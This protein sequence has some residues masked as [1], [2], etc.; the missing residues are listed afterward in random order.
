MFVPYLIGCS[1]GS[2]LRHWVLSRSAP[3]KPAT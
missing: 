2:L 3:A 1:A